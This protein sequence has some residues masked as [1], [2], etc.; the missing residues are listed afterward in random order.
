MAKKVYG[1]MLMGICWISLMVLCAPA[2]LV[3][4]VGKDGE[5]TI[6]NA[7]GLLWCGGLYLLFNKKKINP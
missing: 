5:L 1:W 6:W 4:S 7:V 3:F 2:L